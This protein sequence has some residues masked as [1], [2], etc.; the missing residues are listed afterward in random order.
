MKYRLN[1]KIFP[2]LTRLVSFLAGVHDVAAQCRRSMGRTGSWGKAA[3]RDSKE[4][5]HCLVAR[6]TRS[7]MLGAG[8][9][10]VGE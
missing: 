1:A 6:C 5:R 3:N 9:G 4:M 8:P 10:R 7:L 2:T